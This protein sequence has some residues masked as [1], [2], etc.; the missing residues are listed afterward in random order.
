MFS[1]FASIAGGLM[2]LIGLIG[3]QSKIPWAILCWRTAA[4]L[5]IASGI[6]GIIY[7]YDSNWVWI[8]HDLLRYLRTVVGTF[9]GGM[10][11]VLLLVCREFESNKKTTLS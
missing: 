9:A 1:I 5:F 10:T 2:I 6:L 7:G 8:H 4:L 11:V 3:K